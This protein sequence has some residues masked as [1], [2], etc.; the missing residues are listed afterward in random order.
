V[1]APD[2]RPCVDLRR[3][4]AT[5]IWR[6]GPN[7]L[8]SAVSPKGPPGAP[9]LSGSITDF[10]AIAVSHLTDGA[11][12]QPAGSLLTPKRKAPALATTERFVSD[13]VPGSVPSTSPSVG[14]RNRELM[15][16]RKKHRIEMVGA[17]GPT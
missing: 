9:R 13:M 3:E 15:P 6:S 14:H 10:G 17:S 2:H 8:P 12:L 16:A 1:P 11:V 5:L 7:R 4:D